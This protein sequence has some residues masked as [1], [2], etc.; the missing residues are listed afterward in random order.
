MHLWDILIPGTREDC[1][2]YRRPLICGPRATLALKKNIEGFVRCV[3]MTRNHNGTIDARCFIDYGQF[4]DGVDLAAY[5]L[6]RGWAR[7]TGQGV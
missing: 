2:T 6:N 3:E 1:V 4:D 7:E 5:L